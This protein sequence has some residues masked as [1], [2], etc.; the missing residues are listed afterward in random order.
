MNAR[1]T[2]QGRIRS[3]DILAEHESG[4]I[5]QHFRIF[6]LGHKLPLNDLMRTVIGNRGSRFPGP[7]NHLGISQ[8]IGFSA[9]KPGKSMEIAE[10][11][12]A[13]EFNSRVSGRFIV[14]KN[15]LI[16]GSAAPL[17]IGRDKRSYPAPR[18]GVPRA[19]AVSTRFFLSA[20]NFAVFSSIKD[21]SCTSKIV[22]Y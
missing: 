4:K 19:M 6:L 17:H 8:F 20:N 5:P 22:L 7:V 14:V 1:Q 13:V 15:I 11:V 2:F 12:L 9:G 3:G 10:G 16:T 18:S 21:S